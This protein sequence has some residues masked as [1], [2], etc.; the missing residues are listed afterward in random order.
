[1]LWALEEFEM[2]EPIK[3]ASNNKI[4]A[5]ILVLI[6]LVLVVAGL[7]IIEIHNPLRGS[8]AGTASLVLGIVVF[9]VGLWR[10]SLHR[11]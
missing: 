5:Y 10:F 6:G 3:T 9:I 8:G 2:G 4:R 7:A 11:S 1:M